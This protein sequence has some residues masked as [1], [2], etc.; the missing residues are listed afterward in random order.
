MGS[1]PHCASK[2]NTHS[3]GDKMT[4]GSCQNVINVD[5]LPFGSLGC[6]CHLEEKSFHV[7]TDFLLVRINQSLLACIT[8]ITVRMELAM[9]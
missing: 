2:C 3:L 9:L 4:H 1:N 8:S 5:V 6:V 7:M